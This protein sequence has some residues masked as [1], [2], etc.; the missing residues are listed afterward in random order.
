MSKFKPVTASPVKHPKPYQV[1]PNK[2]PI[3][4]HAGRLR[5]QVGKRATA[6]I[7]PRFGIRHGGKLVK[8]GK[9][10]NR[11]EWHGNAPPS[12]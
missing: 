6:A 11:P 10:D 4:D 3:Y 5:G 7:L 8:Q 12:K 9:I 2:V 1:A